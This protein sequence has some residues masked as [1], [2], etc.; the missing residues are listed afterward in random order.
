MRAVVTITQ[1][2]EWDAMH[3]IPGHEGK[4]KAFHGH[5]YVAEITVTAR[6]LDS[7]GRIIDFAVIKS[8]VGKWIDDFFDHTAILWKDDKDPAV[9]AIVAANAAAG[10]P[11]YLLDSIPTVENIASEL[12]QKV[13]EILRAREISLIELRLWETPNCSA[14]WVNQ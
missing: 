13:S 7:L 5:R 2:L 1:R 12:A 11:A 8:Q 9:G 4:C 6:S 14:G 3:R 10:R